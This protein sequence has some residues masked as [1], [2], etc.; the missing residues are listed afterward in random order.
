MK[1]IKLNKKQIETVKQ[2]RST[3]VGHLKTDFH[4]N[5]K[6]V[7]GLPIAM[8]LAIVEKKTKRYIELN[9]SNWCSLSYPKKAIELLR[10]SQG[11]KNTNYFKILIEGNKNIYY[12]HPEYGHEDYNKSIAF[13]K[14][15][16]TLRLMYLV[17]TILAG[18][19]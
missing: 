4:G 9:K 18:R 16:K 17:N 12:A 1:K 14:N 6:K 7:M 2:I 3:P 13:P 8:Y 10:N 19:N 11:L 5:T 15:T